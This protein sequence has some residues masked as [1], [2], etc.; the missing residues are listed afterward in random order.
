M[1]YLLIS[2]IGLYILIS[3]YVNVCAHIVFLKTFYLLTLYTFHF[4]LLSAS[5]YI[6][7]T[8]EHYAAV[9]SMCVYRFNFC[10]VLM[11]LCIYSNCTFIF[12]TV[13]FLLYHLLV[14]VHYVLIFVTVTPNSLYKL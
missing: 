11:V 1:V 5:L 6:L 13:Y 4:F 2:F 14:C 12:F 3:Y 9:Q 8:C 7:L 10:N